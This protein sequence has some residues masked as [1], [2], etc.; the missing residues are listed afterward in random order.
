M[1][2]G[3]IC[4]TNLASANEGMPGGYIESNAKNG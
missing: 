2:E 4:R 3:L 1:K